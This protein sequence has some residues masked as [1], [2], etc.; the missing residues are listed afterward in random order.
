MFK[1][2]FFLIASLGI[3]SLLFTRSTHAAT[4]GA[5]YPTLGTAVAESPWSDND[6][7]TPTNIYSDNASTA[8][9]TA[10]TFDNGDQTSVLKATGFDF[11]AIPDGSTINGVIMRANAWY[12]SG[13]GSGAMDLCQLLNVS[14]AKVGTNNCSTQVALT[15]TNSTIITKGSSS[16]LWG[17]SLTTAWIKDPEFGVAIGVKATANNAD[18]DVD[19]VTLE[20]YYTPPSTT[21]ADGTNPSSSTI[22]PGASTTDLDS[23]T[24]TTSGGTDSVTA[25]TV[26]LASNTYAGLSE[27]QI[28]SDDG[29]TT[30]FSAI[31][32]PTSDTLNFSGGTALPVT[33][34]TTTFKI[35]IIPKSHANMPAPDGSSYSVTGTIT[36]FT[37]TNTQLGSDAGSATITVDNDSPAN[38]TSASAAAGQELVNL[39]WTNPADSDYSQ[40]L[41]L[42]RANSAVTDTPTE[43]STYTVTDIVGSSTVVCLTS[44]TSCSVTN[45]TGGTAYHY[46][47]FALD[48]RGNYS[49]TGTTP[50][51]SPAT[52]TTVIISVTLTTD[53]TISYGITPLGTSKDTTSASLNDTQTFQN[54][55]NVAEDFT[56]KTSNALGGTS[57]IINA[58]AGSDLF[59][60][61]FSLNSGS[62]WTPFSS[63]DSY[64]TLLANLAIDA[65]QALDFRLTTPT[66]STD[67]IE[68][69]VTITIQAT[70][71]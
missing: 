63:A 31:T 53:G 50:S 30:Y 12:R 16:D 10:A 18:V 68:K 56:I 24:L 5:A 23:F 71:H 49:A 14:K 39:S 8:N 19:Y 7:A 65:T 67:Y 70:Q 69:T 15:T 54:N 43:G 59:V 33:T 44:S 32:N 2:Y 3:W 58:T 1:R 57:W 46:Q 4:T 34:T 26:T 9:V 6:W 41:V 47:I 52:P 25:A 36:A 40:T 51:G 48:S 28:T 27:V 42:Q 17:N 55:G 11:S 64:Q 13:T 62:L 66:S 29:T 35:R 22:T 20:I 21:L 38:V 37:S 61:Q 60:H 45:L